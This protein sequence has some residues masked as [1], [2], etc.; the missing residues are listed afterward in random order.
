MNGVVNQFAGAVAESVDRAFVRLA[1]RSRRASERGHTETSAERLDEAARFYPAAAAEGRL[2]S[3][4]PPAH[5]VER[6]V[7]RIPGGEVVDVAWPSSYRPLHPGYVEFAVRIPPN[8]IAVARWVRH[9]R[10]SPTVVFLHGWGGGYFGILER[11]ELTRRLFQ[12]GAD[13]FFPALPFHGRRALARF[14]RPTFP[15]T[16]PMRTNEGFAQAVS[17]LRAL[18]AALRSRGAPAVAVMGR[19]LGGFTTAL[20]A[21]V[22]AQLDAVVPV[23]PFG[24]IAELMWEQGEGT[25]ARQRAAEAGVTFERFAAAFDATT[26]ILR[27]PA[28]PGDRMLIVAGER[29]RVTPIRH[30]RK[31]RDHFSRETGID[32]PIETFPG[33]HLVQ[34]GRDGATLRMLDFLRARGLLARS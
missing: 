1:F 11:E 19:S 18:I 34:A 24:S 10:P 17:D 25:S 22:E 29:D 6:P 5:W 2:F 9:P 8:A 3:A 14:E 7:R 23:I 20:L 4:P 16:D 27:K 33:G 13:V 30:A 21:T 15:S 31:L 28:I 12:Q 32:V 26:P